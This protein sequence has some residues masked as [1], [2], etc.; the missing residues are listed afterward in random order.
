MKHTKRQPIRNRPKYYT[1]IQVNTVLGLAAVAKGRP[2]RVNGCKVA[3]W[4]A[5]NALLDVNVNAVPT[6]HLNP[7][8]EQ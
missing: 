8:P 2:T 1:P 3:L 6:V 4:K 5:N 7:E